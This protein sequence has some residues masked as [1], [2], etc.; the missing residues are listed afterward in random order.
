MSKFSL[1]ITF[2][3]FVLVISNYF[4]AFESCSNLKS[5]SKLPKQTRNRM[6]TN[7]V[8]YSGTFYM[9]FRGA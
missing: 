1:Q 5:C 4:W 8:S 2:D 3:S 7:Y 9:Y 6:F